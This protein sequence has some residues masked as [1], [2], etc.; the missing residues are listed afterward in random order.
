MLPVIKRDY[1]NT[2]SFT[3]FVTITLNIIN[4][5]NSLSNYNI[6]GINYDNPFTL[7][8]QESKMALLQDSG[9]AYFHFKPVRITKNI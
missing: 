9:Y 2:I 5:Q 4:L 8:C 1:E 7:S 3:I 6:Y